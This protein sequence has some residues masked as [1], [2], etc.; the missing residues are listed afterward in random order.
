MAFK[1]RRQHRYELLRSYG[2]LPF[3]AQALSN[4][5]IK[6]PYMDSLIKQRYKEL[7]KAVKDKLT[8]EQ[9]HRKII[10]RYKSHDW[11]EVGKPTKY[12]P[13]AMLREFEHTYKQQHP[14]YESP[15]KKRRKKF[16]DFMRTVE[17]ELA[18][19]P[20][21]RAMTMETRQR[22]QKQAEEADRQFKYIREQR[23]KSS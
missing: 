9:W 6:V 18:E 19:Q 15:W 20:K 8:K 11:F 5:P 10:D 21:L 17:K 14:E 13:H 12:S 1:T 4:V 3:E 22:L 23:N 2:F 7:R 16:V